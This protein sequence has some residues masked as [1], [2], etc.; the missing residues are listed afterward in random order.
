MNK[1]KIQSKI[2][3]GQFGNAVFFLRPPSTVGKIKEVHEKEIMPMTT[4]NIIDAM[5]EGSYQ[6]IKQ[7]LKDE[8]VNFI[9]LTNS[10]ED[11]SKNAAASLCVYTEDFKFK[12]VLISPNC[13]DSRNIIWFKFNTDIETSV[14]EIIS[15]IEYIKKH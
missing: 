11:H 3:I 7:S 10:K 1:R 14:D 4:T 12:Y 9:F 8:Q 2:A 6:Y 15:V 5:R 13:M